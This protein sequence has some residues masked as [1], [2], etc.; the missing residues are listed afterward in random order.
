MAGPVGVISVPHELFTTGGVGTTCAELTQATVDPPA[1]G[2]TKVGAD[3]VY[4]YTHGAEVPVQSVYVQVYV[5]VPEQTGS[6]PTTGPV[7]VIGLPHELFTTGG[8]GTVCALLIQATVEAPLA[9]N[10]NVG[11]L[12][13]YVY[14]Q[15]DDIPV[16]SVYVQV[17]VFVPEQPARALTPWLLARIGELTDGA[18]IRANTALIVN[19]AGVAGALAVLLAEAVPG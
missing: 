6:G 17:Y 12:I 2:T 10:E 14:T 11:G 4:V 15:G 3:I 19:N 18:S 13:V 5:F 9:G 7:G 8:V 16:Q 1:A